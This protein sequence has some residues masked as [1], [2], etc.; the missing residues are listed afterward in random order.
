MEIVRTG[1]CKRRNDKEND[2]EGPCKRFNISC[3]LL[4]FLMNRGLVR[5]V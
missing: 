3:P 4:V 5:V 1:E 2:K